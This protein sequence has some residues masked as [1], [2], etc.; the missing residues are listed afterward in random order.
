M[1]QKIFGE[2][3]TFKKGVRLWEYLSLRIS[4]CISIYFFRKMSWNSWNILELRLQDLQF[5]SFGTFF[6]CFFTSKDIQRGFFQ[7]VGSSCSRALG[8]AISCG[9]KSVTWRTWLW[10]GRGFV[11]SEA[12]EFLSYLDTRPGKHTKNYGTS[13]FLMGKST[14]NGHFQ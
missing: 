6:K 4:I 13:P 1:P 9:A 8:T 10:S 7:L 5:P 14:I 11:C 2:S 12:N 3:L